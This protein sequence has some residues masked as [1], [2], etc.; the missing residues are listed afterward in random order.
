MTPELRRNI[1]SFYGNLN[2]PIATKRNKDAWQKTLRS[3]DR[4][5]AS[6]VQAAGDTRRT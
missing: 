5:K 3:L 6:P 2:A 4:L 1:L